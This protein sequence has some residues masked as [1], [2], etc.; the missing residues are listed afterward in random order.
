MRERE[1]KH[2]TPRI[3]RQRGRYFRPS[4]GA[5]C[6]RSLRP[7]WPPEA[8][9]S[10]ARGTRFRQ[11]GGGGALGAG[12]PPHRATA[13]GKR[14]HH[15]LGT[16]LRRRL[17]RHRLRDFAQGVPAGDTLRARPLDAFDLRHV[18]CRADRSRVSWTAQPRLPDAL[19]RRRY[20][21]PDDHDLELSSAIRSTAC[22]LPQGA[23]ADVCLYSHCTADAA[24]R[25]ALCAAR[26]QLRRRGVAC[27][28]HLC[29]R[30]SGWCGA[31]LHAQ[32]RRLCHLLQDSWRSRD[33]QDPIDPD[34]NGHSRPLALTG[35]PAARRLGRRGIRG[36]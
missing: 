31:C 5:G 20:W 17:L 16:S 18:H 24:F 13:G 2:R 34:G 3:I 36:E 21:R 10:D 19:R 12:A 28:L 27:P 35:P 6:S 8:L 7:R 11:A 29:G 14:N 26:R 4:L 22:A 32:L 23:D 1:R 30:G 9:H 15:R 25:A 33:R